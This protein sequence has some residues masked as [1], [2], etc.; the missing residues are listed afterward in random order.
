MVATAATRDREMEPGRFTEKQVMLTLALSAYRGFAYF[1]PAVMR[2]AQLRSAIAEALRDLPPL[3]GRFRLVWGPST[4][5]APLTALDD[6]AMYVVADLRHTDRYVIVIRGTNPVS[7]FDWVFGDFWTA[8]TIPWRPGSDAGDSDAAVSLSSALGLAVLRLM[9]S[10]AATPGLTGV[11]WRFLSEGLSDPLRRAVRKPLR[12]AG[13]SVSVLTQALP[14]LRTNLRRVQRSL[15][16]LPSDPEERVRRLTA[17]WTAPAVASVLEHVDTLLEE[18][19]EDA[20]LALLRLLSGTARI[21]SLLTPGPDLVGFLA[22]V[23]AST[24]EPVEIDVTGHSKGA[25]LAT[26]L[27]LWLAEEKAADWDPAGSAEVG[28]YAFAGPTAGNAAF[29]ARVD[30]ILGTGNRRVVNV[31]DIV[32]HA[33][34]IRGEGSTE[35]LYLDDIPDLYPPPVHHIEALRPLADAVRSQV[36]H[37]DYQHPR[38]NLQTLEGPIAPDVRPWLAQVAHQHIDAYIHE[39][40]LGGT[41]DPRWFFGLG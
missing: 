27:A 2:R 36:A 1:T 16:A 20:D 15:R 25:A 4:F 3:Q 28:C 30:Q 39:L 24:D 18:P 31:L 14:M 9:R 41:L 23:V 37:L 33:W 35:D 40:G 22:S 13:D 26:T 5:R 32:P 38:A 21:R 29:A 34:T 12:A 10:P 11:A 17:V 6:A 8:R 19:G 7:A